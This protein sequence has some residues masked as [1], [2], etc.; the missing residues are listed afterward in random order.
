MKNFK[1]IIIFIAVF[2]LLY[3]CMYRNI[4]NLI[5]K[6][7]DKIYT[8]ANDTKQENSDFIYEMFEHIISLG[9]YKAISSEEE[10]E[11]IKKNSIL[12]NLINNYVYEAK[13]SESMLKKVISGLYV[14]EMDNTIYGDLKF[15]SSAY[16]SNKALDILFV[17][18]YS[19]DMNK[20][21]YLNLSED[22]TSASSSTGP[23]IYDGNEASDENQFEQNKND[24]LQKG[25]N[26]FLRAMINTKFDPD[27][28][29]KQ[30]E[31]RY[32]LKD[33]T[34]DITV[35]YNIEKDVIVGFFMGFE[36]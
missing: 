21:Y 11:N 29:I 15:I 7:E 24:I 17:I 4:D 36:K 19:E 3:F 8:F 31:Y 22:G 26:A 2:L 28:I 35:Y 27:T 32:I 23:V 18:A 25:I 1:N 6:Y 33:T 30:N 10:I 14:G 9:N 12:Y 34:R 13:L 16:S 5:P 20:V